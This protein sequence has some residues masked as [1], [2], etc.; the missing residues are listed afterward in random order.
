MLAAWFRSLRRSDELGV[1]CRCVEPSY[2]AG[3]SLKSKALA[4]VQSDL[5]DARVL[6]TAQ[7]SRARDADDD[8]LQQIGQGDE[9]AFRL[10]VARHIDRAYA[11][12]L[13]IL[14][15]PTDTEDV[16]Q[17]VMVKVWTKRC[18]ERW[19][20]RAPPPR[21]LSR[22]D[23]PLPLC[24]PPPE[25]LRHR[26]CA[27]NGKSRPDAL[28][29]LNTGKVRLILERAPRKAARVKGRRAA[30]VLQRPSVQFQG[31]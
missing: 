21:S 13:R 29:S 17:D 15:N 25:H 27:E 4:A 24:Q 12:A 8:L 30:L 1:V 2:E 23:Q 10:L 20:A 9:R 6:A 11:L 26:Q 28:S 3:V 18:L 16:V 7:E 22:R 31:R 19:R 5:G 14:S